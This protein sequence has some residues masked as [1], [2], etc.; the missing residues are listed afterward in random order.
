MDIR[1]FARKMLLFA[2]LTVSC[3]QAAVAQ[4]KPIADLVPSTNAMNLGLF[5]EMPVSLNTGLPDISVPL[6]TIKTKTFSVPI[7]LSYHASGVMPEVHPSWAGS[8]WSLSAGGSINRVINYLPDE[9]D[10]PILNWPQ[11]GYFFTHNANTGANWAS[12]ARMQSYNP[13]DLGYDLAPDVFY[14]SFPGHNGKFFLDENGNWRVQ[15]DQP[16]KVQFDNNDFV[17]PFIDAY[18]ESYNNDMGGLFPFNK[19]TLIDEHG[20]KYVFGEES[21]IE[22][23]T[24]IITGTEKSFK[25]SSWQ[26]RRIISADGIDIVEFNYERGPFQSFLANNVGSSIINTG[27]Y[28]FL[29]LGCSSLTIGMTHIGKVVSPVYLKSITYTRQSLRL[30]FLTSVSNELAY[31]LNNDYR[32]IAWD[33][34]GNASTECFTKLLDDGYDIPYYSANGLPV[35]RANRFIWFKLDKINIVDTKNSSTIRSAN[36]SYNNIA[37]ERLK[38]LNLE[39]HD[40]AD[41]KVQTY[42]FGYNTSALPDYLMSR[43]DHWGFNNGAPP[44]STSDGLSLYTS[45]EPHPVNCKNGILEEITWPTGGKTKFEYSLHDYSG[46]VNRDHATVDALSGTAGG[47]RVTKITNVSNTGAEMIK[48]YYYVHNYQ[49]GVDPATLPSSGI[50]DAIPKYQYD[51]TNAVDATG[52]V[53]N[54]SVTS[55]APVIPLSH[56]SSGQHIGYS[57][58][59]EKRSDGAYTL[60]KFTNHDNGY[61]DEDAVNSYNRA[62]VPY[63]PRSVKDFERGRML[64]RT[65]YDNTGKAIQSETYDY[66]RLTTGINPARSIDQDSKLLCPM[67]PDRGFFTH[68][69]WYLYDYPFVVKRITTKTF[70]SRTTPGNLTTTKDF[71]YANKLTKTVVQ[72]DS[73]LNQLQVNNS[74]PPDVT[75]SVYSSMV[76]KNMLDFTIQ[77]DLSRAGN[78]VKTNRTDFNFWPNG[79]IYPQY[80]KEIMPSGNQKIIEQAEAYDASGNII[81]HTPRSG[82]RES[83]LWGYNSLFPIAQASNAAANE[84]F[85]NGFEE[86][87]GWDNYMTAYDNTRSHTGNYSGRIDKPTSG[88]QVSMG[89][90]WLTIALSTPTKYKYSAWVYSTGPSVDLFL[91]M[92]RTGETGYYSYVDVVST[93]ATGQW[94]YLEKEFSVPADVT[95][96]N[97]RVDNNGGGSVWYDDVRLCPSA[98]QMSTYTFDPLAGMTSVTD[99]ND[100][101]TFYEYDGFQRLQ[102]IRDKD[103]NIIKQFDYKYLYYPYDPTPDWQPTG[104]YQCEKNTYNFNTGLRQQEQ[105]DHNPYSPTLNTL[106]WVNIGADHNSCPLPPIYVSIDYENTH[107]NQGFFGDVVVRFWY[108]QYGWQ[109]YPVTGV[110]VNY[111]IYNSATDTYTYDGFIANGSVSKVV[112]TNTQLGVAD[113]PN[114]TVGCSYRTI[115]YDLSYSDDYTRIYSYNNVRADYQPIGPTRCQLNSSSQNTG[116]IEQQEKD[117]NPHSPS[118]GSL[119]WEAFTYD[120]NTCPP[121]VN[122]TPSWIPTGNIRCTTDA[123]HH[124]TGNQEQE[125]RDTNPN[126]PTGGQT[127]WV[128]V[129]ANTTSCPLIYVNIAFENT[130]TDDYGGTTADIVAY[131]WYDAAATLPASVSNLRV[132]YSVNDTHLNTTTSGNVTANGTRAV[133]RQRAITVYA[134]RNNCDPDNEF[135]CAIYYINYYLEAG[136]YGITY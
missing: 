6:Y 75:G 126:S 25:A 135:D 33:A 50:L 23:S 1:S 128:N 81:Q 74:Y 60:F 113:D 119:T 10:I 106:R 79:G 24:D 76:Q 20:I 58:V 18:A 77:E 28:G 26:L 3:Y 30:D 121:P 71:T 21:A 132:N 11:R 105:K 40:K 62:F 34:S 8:G 4:F 93:T 16:V 131:F 82:L 114:C 41:Q 118:F 120:A 111:S 17:K 69:A 57:E 127:R 78:L 14:F 83:F 54:Y 95:Q 123:S 94:V 49:P 117:M 44:Y 134:D 136:N 91:F 104:N 52:H 13:F 102:R 115:D 107:Y 56:T 70:E 66:D 5:T 38:L 86:G 31:K 85:F 37:T 124:N 46:V 59:V 103:R 88:E 112:A 73:K 100:K 67:S 63:I 64:E 9:F 96:L 122:R 43:G 32:P 53:F 125:E 39:L 72:T 7:T 27:D 68:S 130:D 101:A 80:V 129:G 51:I 35:E 22:Y 99:A 29:N 42:S 48:Q 108:D 87:T 109:P 12:D 110:P 15:C 98:A 45:K 97:I 92:K 65:V 2:T 19:F 36:F 55:S 89:S 90:G 47:L 84:F 116:S 133:L 61:G